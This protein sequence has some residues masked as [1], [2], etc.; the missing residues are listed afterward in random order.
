[1]LPQEVVDFFSTYQD[2]LWL[3]TVAIDLAITL[4]LYR[5]FGKMGLYSIVILNIMLSNLQGPKITVIFGMETSLG[6]ILYSGIYF[7]TDLLSENYGR[8]EANRAVQLG[9]ATSVIMVIMVSISLLFLPSSLPETK[10]FAERVHYAIENLFDFTPLFVFGSLFVYLVSQ[11]FDV[12]VF[13]YVKE[14]T[15]GKHL[16]LRNNVSTIMSQSVDT[17]LYALIV[18]APVVGLEKAIYL[19]LA[20]YFFKVVI[21]ILDTPF[22]YWAR[23]WNVVG[24]DWHDAS[25]SHHHHDSESKKKSDT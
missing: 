18:W 19:S 15:K 17:V 24:K 21:A 25:E 5:L 8:R 6:L 4:L 14:K 2:L 16:W 3:V 9:F 1:M 10:D 20:K 12:W 11:S 13:H 7:A 22:I 23:S